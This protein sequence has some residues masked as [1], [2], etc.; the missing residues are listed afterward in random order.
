MFFTQSTVPVWTS[1]HE[2]AELSV[3]RKKAVHSIPL[4]EGVW[5]KIPIQIVTSELYFHIVLDI[6]I[7]TE[8][9]RPQETVLLYRHQLFAAVFNTR[10]KG[11]QNQ[12][13]PSST[14]GEKCVLQAA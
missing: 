9:L 14:Q 3:P 2:T 13:E 11:H 10:N 1:G 6:S 5:L 4:I 12:Q 8:H 7:R